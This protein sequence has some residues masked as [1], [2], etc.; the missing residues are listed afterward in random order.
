VLVGA[1]DATE[2][3]EGVFAFDRF[4]FDA[5]LLVSEVEVDEGQLRGLSGRMGLAETQRRQAKED[6]H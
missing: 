5:D 1:G 6:E 3:F 2:E 4:A